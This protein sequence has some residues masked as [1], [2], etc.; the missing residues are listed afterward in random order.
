MLRLETEGVWRIRTAV[1]LPDHLHLPVV[2][3]ESADLSRTVRLLKGRLTATLRKGGLRG[4]QVCSDHRLR[5]GEDKLPVFPYLFLNSFRAGML[6]QSE[7]W[8]GYFCCE[9]DLVWFDAL[10]N[11]SA[12]LPEWLA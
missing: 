5:I 12:S 6:A 8:P 10:T 7:M 9:D 3:G 11:E 2:N 1:V 4:Q